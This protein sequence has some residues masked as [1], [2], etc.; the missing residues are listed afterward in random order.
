MK[1]PIQSIVFVLAA[2]VCFIGTNSTA[3]GNAFCGEMKWQTAQNEDHH[4]KSEESMSS[5]K[6][7]ILYDN[8]VF[9]QGTASEWGFS[10]LVQGFEKTILFDTGGKGD[11]LMSNI[12]A[13]GVDLKK[14]D[15]IVLSHNHWDHTGGLLNVLAVNHDVTVYVPQ[16]FPDEFLEKVTQTGAKIERVQQPK[17]VCRNVVLTGEIAG[18][19]NEQSLILKTTQ[20][21][22]VI[23]G[24]S[25]PGIAKIVKTAG[26]VIQGRVYMAFGGFHL[27]RHSENEVNGIIE[28]LRAMGLVKC[29]ATHCT[30]EKA[31]GQF[32]SAFGANFLQMGTG[33]VIEIPE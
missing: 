11:I 30:G 8:Y 15:V 13:L 9:A 23:T 19:V 32:K 28:E 6:V 4:Q 17:V 18:P 24:C 3:G 31:I 14:V 12:G 22:V 1:A 7:T 33:N 2:F 16:S 29:G 25:H 5:K 21:A 26:D 10:C 27:M 20:G